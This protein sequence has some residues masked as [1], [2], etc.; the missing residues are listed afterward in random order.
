MYY[1]EWLVGFYFHFIPLCGCLS[2]AGTVNRLMLKDYFFVNILS[3][4]GVTACSVGKGNFYF[5]C[6]GILL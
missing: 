2:S 4:S 6:T 3:A 1:S 5:S